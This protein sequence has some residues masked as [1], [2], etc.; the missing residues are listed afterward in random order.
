MKK[1][2]KALV[3]LAALAAIL[4]GGWRGMRLVQDRQTAVDRD[5]GAVA[6]APPVRVIVQTVRQGSLAS[7]VWVTGEI[8]AV[9]SVEIAPKISG[10]LERLRLPDGR[11]VEEGVEVE[12]GQTVAVIEHAQ[13]EAAVRAAQAAL[14]VAKAARET[15]KVNLADALREKGRWAELRKQGSGTQQQLD[16]AA[17]AHER[18]HA[19]FKQAEAQIAQSEAALAQ[20][21][22][23]LDE[24]TIEAPFSGLV[25]RKHV[26]E[27][28]F[29]GPSE[30]RRRGRRFPE[31]I[32]R[33]NR[34]SRASRIG[35]RHSHRRRHDLRAQSRTAVEARYV[36]S[37]PARA[38]RTQ[39]RNDRSR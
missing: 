34:Q 31:R 26:D 2:L 29:V 16:Q 33:G 35:S 19:Q 25:T 9:R 10:R 14:E 36:R 11:A 12:E 3:W 20:A 13:L 37:H 18:A 23:N 7:S 15:A 8:R 24:A 27:G 32:L 1:V 21:R 39:G 6:E 28:A 38:R 5:A 4:Y 17:T 30:R 22:V